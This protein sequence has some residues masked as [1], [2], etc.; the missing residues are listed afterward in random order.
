MGIDN[1]AHMN[2][3]DNHPINLPVLLETRLLV[4]AGSG[5]G[6]SWALRRILEQTAPHVQQLVIDPDG[7]FATLREKPECNIAHNGRPRQ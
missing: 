6:K 5:G 2:L 7:E 1:Q 4:Q 3:S